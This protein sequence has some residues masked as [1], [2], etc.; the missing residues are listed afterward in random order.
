MGC[1][2]RKNNDNEITMSLD[3]G[4][5]LNLHTRPNVCHDSLQSTVRN[6]MV[7]ISKAAKE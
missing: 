1:R 3:T 6:M 2:K 4:K 7:P 5:K